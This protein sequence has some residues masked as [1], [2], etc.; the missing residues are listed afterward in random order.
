MSLQAPF[1]NNN[2]IFRK[3]QLVPCNSSAKSWKLEGLLR[4]VKL[5]GEHAFKNT[6][7]GVPPLG[8][9]ALVYAT[10]PKL[11]DGSLMNRN[12][13]AQSYKLVYEEFSQKE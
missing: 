9:M 8:F 12:D 11:G 10:L 3:F 6:G 13:F 7:E 1:N 2:G 4:R 5:V